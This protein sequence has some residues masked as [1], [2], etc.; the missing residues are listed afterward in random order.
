MVSTVRD[1]SGLRRVKTKIIGRD[2]SY[3][4]RYPILLSS[5]HHIV[6]CLIRD[7]HLRYSHAGIQALTAIMREEFW[8]IG[9]RRAIRS[10]VKQC[11]R[12]KRISTKPLTTAPIQ[13][14]LDRVRDSFVFEVTV[15]RC[16][17]LELV[18]SISTE[19]FIQAFRH[20]I[21]RR[22][23]LCIVYSDNGTNFVG[24]SAG[25]K[26]V[27]DWKKVVS[28]ETLNPITW[29]FIPPT[30]AWW[31]GWWERLIRSVKNL[32]VTVLGQASVNYEELLT[33]LSDIRVSGTADLDIL[34]RNEL[35]VRQR[36]LPRAQGADAEPFLQGVSGTVHPETCT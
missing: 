2:D 6:N 13:F 4:F 21:T 30:A 20:F 24:A 14:P 5:R 22:G 23:Q 27:D 8:I 10:V 18:T 25:L 32:I 17:Y 15:Y 33:I 35:L 19:C 31:G 36:F 16:V 12:C 11:V 34:D 1:Q 9:A 26:K 3:A 28:Q 7:Y 29:K